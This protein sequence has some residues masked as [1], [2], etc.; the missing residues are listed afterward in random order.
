VSD[1]HVIA[2][3]RWPSGTGIGI[4][5]NEYL[6][7]APLDM[8]VR[9]LDLKGRIGHP[10]SP[11][12][13]GA[14]LAFDRTKGKVFWSPGFVPPAYA[15]IPSVVT[16]HDL[17]HLHFYSSLHARYYSLVFKPIYKRCRAVICVS[18]YTR[19]EFLDWSG[20]ASDRV[21]TVHNG[22]SADFRS[23]VEPY[24]PGYPYIFYPGNKR[25][26]KNL[27][28]MLRA[29]ARS[30]LPK[31]GIKVVMTGA[32]TPELQA[33]IDEHR[34]VE[35]VVFVGFI[36]DEKLPSLYR[37]AIFTAFISLYEGFGLPIVESMAV[38]TPVLTSNVSSMPEIAANAAW[39]VSPRN[40]DEI[41][42]AM[43]ELVSD[44]ALRAELVLKGFSRA[45]AFSW[46]SAATT[47][48]NI[49]RSAGSGL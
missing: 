40:L 8:S 32:T 24:L 3:L 6:A 20:M 12:V 34:M 44:D 13:M 17:T 47:T 15:G 35:N 14:K 7:R 5:Q 19:N 23:D 49:I 29:Y 45:A 25:A 2:D 37:G 18:E 46:D 26:Y 27:G 10:L 39:L 1:V 22:V 28:M 4:C 9:A 43:D 38:G 33:I 36:S 16:V 31:L 41:V 21:H 48:W 30:S 11:F 42:Y